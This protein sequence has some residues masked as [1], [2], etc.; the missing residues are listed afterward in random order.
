MLQYAHM[1][2]YN[3]SINDELAEIVEYMMKERKYANRS[4]FFREL[5]RRHY[6]ENAD[7]VIEA[8]DPS[9]PDYKLLEK[10][11]KESG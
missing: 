5:I 11:K 7:Y 2:H 8:L 9:D 3:I 1:T 6:L 10:R 4:E